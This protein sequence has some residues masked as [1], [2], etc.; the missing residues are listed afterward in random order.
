[1][2]VVMRMGMVIRLAAILLGIGVATLL[3]QKASG[4]A[5]V[6]VVGA[7][8]DLLDTMITRA[9]EPIGQHAVA[10]AFELFH[11]RHIYPELQ[12]HW[13][14]AVTLLWLLFIAMLQLSR[15]Q[16]VT[17][18]GLNLVWAAICAMAAGVMAGSVPLSDPRWMWCGLAGLALWNLGLQVVL[19][20]FGSEAFAGIGLFAFLALI[21]AGRIPAH[22]EFVPPAA[23]AG[24]LC[25]ALATTLLG[26]G[27]LAFGAFNSSGK[28]EDGFGAWLG[29]PCTREGLSILS[30]IG[31][32]AVAS[33]LLF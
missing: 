3:A 33:G 17:A 28:G 25:A 9:F 4:I 23:S 13:M 15:E 24:L 31:G 7:P 1:M 6:R 2:G 32:A 26:A 12:G 30:V 14:W 5:V 20:S 22:I 11:K 27:L 18:Y 21:A 10:P 16:G 19:T 29:D 8:L